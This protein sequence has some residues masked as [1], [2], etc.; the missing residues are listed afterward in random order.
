MNIPYQYSAG[1]EVMLHI[2]KEYKYEKA[3]LGPRTIVETFPDGTVSLQEGPVIDRV[4]IRRIHQYM[5]TDPVSRGGEEC[6]VHD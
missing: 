4:N 1:N 3:Y 2:G 5:E 6:T